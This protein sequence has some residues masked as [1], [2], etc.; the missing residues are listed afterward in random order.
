M[1]YR[2]NNKG[3]SSFQKSRRKGLSNPNGSK[4]IDSHPFQ[5]EKD[6]H[7]WRGRE[8]RKKNTFMRDTA[9]FFILLPPKKNM[10]MGWYVVCTARVVAT[11]RHSNDMC[12]IS[13]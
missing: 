8:T 1:G 13:Q 11:Q 5:Q 4:I 7:V 12:G 2:L 3:G 9:R 10:E 6:I